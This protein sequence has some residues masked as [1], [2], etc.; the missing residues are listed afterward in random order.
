MKQFRKRVKPAPEII[1]NL[2]I[3]DAGA[4]GK[5]IAKHNGVVIFIPFG[6]PGDSVDVEITYK[7]RSF[8]EGSILKIHSPSPFRI[9]P[10]CEHFGICGGCKWQ[11]LSY[12]QQLSIKQKHVKDNLERIAKVNQPPLMPVIQS[13]FVKHYRNKLEYTFGDRRWLTR[14]EVYS[15]TRFDQRS[16]GFHIP[17]RFDKII[18]VDKCYLQPDPSDSIRNAVYD[19]TISHELEFFNLK[20]KTGFVRN[21]II[22]NN[23]KGEVMLIWV[24]SEE[25]TDVF[26]EFTN[27]MTSAFPQIVSLY[28]AINNKLNDSLEG[29]PFVHLS[30]AEYLTEEMDGLKFHIAPASFF[31]TNT[32]QAVK[33]YN[34]ALEM[35]RLKGDELVYDLYTGTATIAAFLSRHAAKVIG[36]EYSESAVL[37]GKKNL[38]INGIDNVDLYHG[39]MSKLFNFQWVKKK[40][41]PDVIVTDP[42]RAGMH[43]SVV[44]TI[45]ELRPEKIVY[46]SCNPATQAR[47][48]AEMT[49]EYEVVKVQPVDMFPQTHH[50]ENIVLLHR[51][52]Q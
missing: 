5:A 18:H 13:D 49:K 4:E 32:A 3:T 7:R 12:E 40:G 21:L 1:N 6:A 30:G 34:K 31:Q 9:E 44:N 26:D 28:A 27:H 41:F 10:F 45:V 17:G 50:V 33:L 38:E 2:L 35:A 39:D 24:V 14:E 42:P 8:W 51:R 47:D 22:R 23:F 48:I 52:K 46:I 11:H 29:V 43:P 25:R 16:L 20:E 15:D 19:F 37:D 36:I